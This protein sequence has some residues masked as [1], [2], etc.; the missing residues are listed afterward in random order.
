MGEPELAIE[1]VNRAMRLSPNDPQ[2]FSMYTALGVA[3]F[4]AGR[5]PQA[6]TL[7]AAAAREHP[8]FL[9]VQCVVA[10]SAALAGKLEEAQMAIRNLRQL[11]P[12]S[13]ISNLQV[14]VFQRPED[15]V[16]WEE[17][18]RLAGLPE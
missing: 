14:R 6:L 9:L 8:E 15:L 17:G 12:D 2:R 7:A 4:V 11:D 16:R 10:A 13:H 1:H 18:L 3:H 5:Y